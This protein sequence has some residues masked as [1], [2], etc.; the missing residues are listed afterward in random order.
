MVDEN[1]SVSILKSLISRFQA[2]KDEAVATIM[3][4]LRNPTG[5]GDHPNIIEELDKLFAQASE[6]EE[7]LALLNSQ[8]KVRAS[9]DGGDE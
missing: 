9:T 3:V 7:K 6:A 4:Y 2:Q 5:I 8:F 1:V